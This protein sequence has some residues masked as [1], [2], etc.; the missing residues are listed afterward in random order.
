M[1][2]RV[3]NLMARAFVLDR[4]GG[5]VHTHIFNRLGAPMSRGFVFSQ[6]IK[7]NG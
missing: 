4:I 7:S 1:F 5:Q 2:D 3:V 6:L